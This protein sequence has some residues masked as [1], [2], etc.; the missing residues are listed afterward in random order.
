MSSD[1]STLEE[2]EAHLRQNP[3]DASAWNLKGVLLARMER[4]GAA[5]R[6]LDRAIRID[7]KLAEAHT[8]RGRVLMALGDDKAQ[9]ALRSFDRALKLAPDNLT[10]LIDKARVLKALRRRKEEFVC[11][12]KICKLAPEK[13]EAFVRLGDILLEQRQFKTAIESYD[14]A[15]KINDDLVPAYMHRAFALAML[16]KWKEAIRSA[17]TATKLAPEDVEAWRILAEVNLRASKYKSAKKALKKASEI[18]PEDAGI[19]YTLGVVEYEQ[20]HLREALKYFRRALI[21]RKDYSAALRNMAFVLMKLEEWK[22]AAVT[23]EQLTS[24]VRNEPDFF[25]ALAIAYARMDDF[26]SA[27]DSWEKARKLY[28]KKDDPREAKRVTDL[29]RAARINCSKQK[30]A[31]KAQ[32]EHE[33]STRSFDDRH[34]IR[35]KKGRRKKR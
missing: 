28:K 15:L 11:L 1:E 14:R 26:C 35:R 4:F 20:G 18:D 23:F 34:E 32:R 21:R 12:M 25:D 27:A 19:E 30:K 5:L 2:V 3:N 24:I 33:K 10:A 7:S 31:A 16:E 22:E 8:N 29:G 13:W 6:A 9:E 17:E